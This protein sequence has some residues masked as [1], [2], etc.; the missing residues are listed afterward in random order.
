VKL[1]GLAKDSTND[2]A[3]LKV[4]DFIKQES[5]IMKEKKKLIGS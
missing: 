1:N 3:P 4:F 2:A 5:E